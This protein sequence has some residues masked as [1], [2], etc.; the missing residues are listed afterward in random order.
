MAKEMN[1]AQISED[2][3]LQMQAEQRLH[4]RCFFATVDEGFP[5]EPV[6]KD[7]VFPLLAIEHP[8]IF[9]C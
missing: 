9:F 6:I 1:T 5:L 3:A 2:Q 8:A 7:G 4:F